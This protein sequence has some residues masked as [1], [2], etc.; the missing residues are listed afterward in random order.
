M[1]AIDAIHS[2]LQRGDLHDGLVFDAVRVRLIEIG[3][4]VKALPAELL[5]SEPALPWAQIAGMRDHLAHR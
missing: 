5:A 1:A 4:A 3:E 2:H